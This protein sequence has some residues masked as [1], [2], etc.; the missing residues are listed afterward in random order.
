MK[1]AFCGRPFASWHKLAC[2]CGVDA[3]ILTWD[4]L[5]AVSS[6]AFCRDSHSEAERVQ[7]HKM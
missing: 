1:S 5:K 3:E 7:I 4:K 2:C 6:C